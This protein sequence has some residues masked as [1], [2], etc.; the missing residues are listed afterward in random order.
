ME[1]VTLKKTL[2]YIRDDVK[3]PP[4]FHEA[5]IFCVDAQFVKL[6]LVY[7]DDGH[8]PYRDHERYGLKLTS[9]GEQELHRL[10]HR[11][12]PPKRWW[13]LLWPWMPW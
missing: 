7:A 11:N 13:Q 9:R 1:N 2:R 4:E 8:G 3:L 10:E 5:M 12:D 6:T